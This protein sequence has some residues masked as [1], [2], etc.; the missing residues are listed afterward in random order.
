MAVGNTVGATSDSS[1]TVSS[2]LL[3]HSKSNSGSHYSHLRTKLQLLVRH[4]VWKAVPEALEQAEK[5]FGTYDS[6]S[7]T[8]DPAPAFPPASSTQ[9]SS[10]K[11]KENC[12]H[13]PV[14]ATLR[15]HLLVLSVLF[16]TY[17]GDAQTAT[18]RL[19]V[20][21]ALL[22][23]GVLEVKSNNEEE[24]LEGWDQGVVEIP[25]QGSAHP[26]RIRTTPPRVLHALAFLL[27]AVAK[28]NAVG[29][30][31]KKGV[32]ARAGLELR[33]LVGPFGG[34]EGTRLARIKA[35]LMGEVVAISIQRS[36]FPEAQRALDELIA[37]VRSESL[38]ERYQARIAL[39]HGQMAHARGDVGRAR[40]CYEVAAYVSEVGLGGVG[41]SG[42]GLKGK[43]G[44][45]DE[46][47]GWAARAGIV[48]VRLGMLR[49]A[50]QRDQAG[51][52]KEKEGQKAR[53]R[54]KELDALRREGKVLKGECAGRGAALEAIG[55][56]LSA[57]LVEEFLGAKQHLHRALSLATRAQDNHLRALVLALSASHYLH[58]ARQHA[59]TML[60]T[61]AQLAA[62]LGALPKGSGKGR[63][64]KGENVPWNGGNAPLGLWVGERLV[65]L[66][67]L[68]GDM[69][70]AKG[71]EAVNAKLKEAVVGM[72]INV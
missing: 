46:W 4:G 71:Q 66:K 63:E 7:T 29:R 47:V 18:E 11:A 19:S 36:D 44:P 23:T 61:C 30:S 69:E 37:H 8:S 57:C 5:L 54:D 45:T 51:K 70:E 62:G 40:K 42:G 1:Q 9:S 50:S 28:R 53:E 64:K 14:P 72:G 12:G 34:K 48:W 65:E 49:Q 55:E 35:D 2:S 60:G 41:D 38:F 16:H 58:T 13:P 32:F 3:L 15:T 20:L 22:D 27:S 59:L 33:E 39:L 6:L 68:G 10:P 24:A 21:H 17:A 52:G 31:P 26:V 67:R 56:L 43:V 25:L